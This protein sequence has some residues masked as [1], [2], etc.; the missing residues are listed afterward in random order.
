VDNSA[1]VDTSDHEVNLKILLA[2]P[3]VR[4]E[5]SEDARNALLAAMTDDV[6][7][8]VL[9]DNYNQT[10][11]LSVAEASA[12]RDI[13]ADARFFRDLE[14][15]GKLDRAVEFLPPDAAM[16]TL[17]HDG[18]GLTRPELA[19]LLAY[20]KLDL[21]AEILAS[22]LPDDPA[23]A[24]VLSGYFPRRATKAFPREP[25]RHRLRRE[26]VS[27]LLA[28]RIVNLAG[29]VFVLRMRELSGASGAEVARAFVLADGA[30]GLSALKSRIDVLD[31]K[32]DAGLQIRL[33][34][35][36]AG[37]LQLVTPWFLAHLPAGT[38]LGAAI[39]LYRAG[40][41]ALRA[42]LTENDEDQA[43]IES[44]AGHVP[45]DLARDWVS[46]RRLALAPDIA[47][48]A[49]EAS[50]APDT[51]AAL[52]FALGARL[53]LDRLRM[54][55]AK[56]TLPEHW[57]RLALR[58]LLES[59]SA[60]QRG[61]ARILLKEG[62]HDAPAAVDAWAAARAASLERTRAFLSAMESS[63]ELSI[64]KLM[65]ASSQIQTLI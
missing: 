37:H 25:Q 57:D 15:K 8:L 38:D 29:P 64:A 53:G 50:A 65:L 33:Y 13:D 7:H 5:L 32:I 58:R 9:A 55:A 21:D 39:A 36:I 60:T 31:G 41:E 61:L 35:E 2:G 14:T 56:L 63:G 47:L 26:I 34:G 22:D 28:N 20:A 59:L 62:A 43:R 49:H 16:R 11:A 23:F 12:A 48:L 17:A 24:S 52:Y 6:A 42:G 19:V 27:T 54:L 40:V 44:L 46:L 18:K 51:V 4:G 3:R 1:G 10:L 30:F 45:D